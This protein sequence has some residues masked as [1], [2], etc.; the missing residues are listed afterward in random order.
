MKHLKKHSTSAPLKSQRGA[1][2]F[3][4]TLPV[5]FAHA[6]GWTRNISAT[7]VY[8]ETDLVP[9]PG[10]RV[11]FAVELVSQGEKRKLFCDGEV[12]RVDRNNG[13]LGI[14]A[15]LTGSFFSEAVVVID[16]DADFLDLKH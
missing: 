11:H 3:E 6:Y 10:S 7:G 12:V 5:E 1:D 2:R 15:K 14:A 4:S 16:I 9:E 13:V 8:F